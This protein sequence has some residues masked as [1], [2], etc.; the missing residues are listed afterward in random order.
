[1]KRS[2]VLKNDGG[3][4]VRIPKKSQLPLDERMIAMPAAALPPISRDDKGWPSDLEIR[5]EALAD[6][7]LPIRPMDSKTIGF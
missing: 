6:L 3:L 5:F 2:E 1:M 4:A 7:E